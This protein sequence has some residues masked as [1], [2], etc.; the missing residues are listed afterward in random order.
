VIGN[1]VEQSGQFHDQQ[2]GFLGLTDVLGHLPNTVN[3]PPIVTSAV[4][5]KDGLDVVCRAINEA[6]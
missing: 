5:R 1:V 4:A 3:V 6:G 2:I